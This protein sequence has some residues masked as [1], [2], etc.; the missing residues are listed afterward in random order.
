MEVN[1]FLKLM[2]DTYNNSRIKF[3]KIY[4]HKIEQQYFKL[5][6][7]SDKNILDGW[8]NLDNGDSYNILEELREFD[9][10][11]EKRDKLENLQKNDNLLIPFIK[12]ISGKTL[13]ANEMNVAGSFPPRM[14]KD[15][16]DYKEK[17]Y[18]Q[19][20]KSGI[21]HIINK[22]NSDKLKL[23]LRI[24]VKNQRKDIDNCEKP[25]IDSIFDFLEINDNKVK[26]KNTTIHELNDKSYD[27][28]FFFK[29]EKMTTLELQ[30]LEDFDV[31]I[32]TR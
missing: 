32:L 12:I 22:E 13:S 18:K 4:R 8:I 30:E 31:N 2:K 26:Q 3:D 20:E 7:I 28:V 5:K 21:K 6:R 19:L 1:N 11:D 23:T 24:Y 27:D 10:L 17:I 14:S 29:L 15:Y 9:I 16:Y 25:I